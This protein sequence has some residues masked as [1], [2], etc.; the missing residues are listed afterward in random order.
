VIAARARL[1][2]V[3]RANRFWQ[4]IGMLGRRASSRATLA[5]VRSVVCY[6]L[7][8]G[9]CHSG[10]AQTVSVT[11]TPTVDTCIYSGRDNIQ[12]NATIIAG[13][14][15]EGVK[16]R[17]LLR[18]DLTSIPEVATILSARVHLTVVRVPQAAADSDFSLFRMV[19]PWGEEATW[20]NAT[21]NISWE[22]PGALEGTDY[23]PESSATRRISKLGVYEFESTE[24]LIADVQN[25]LDDPASNRGWL[26]KTA[27]EK[28]IETARH[29]GSSESGQP[30]Q[31]L[32]E[33]SMQAG[34]F[35]SEVH[36]QGPNLVL[37]LKPTAPGTYLLETRTN[38]EQ[39][40]WLSV[41]NVSTAE[42]KIVTFT[43]PLV[44]MR[45]FYRAVLQ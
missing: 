2:S 43:V 40:A 11:L 27:S 31:L 45:A 3:E 16:D 26:L 23:F 7:M 17:G 1:L 33:Y 20:S 44:E 4:I 10:T 8:L 25:W 14:R 15:L 38:V 22:A 39:A 30:P 34:P 21:A 24:K 29:F 35:F 5:V 36:R 32:I 37:Q 13:T 9:C 42:L 6:G 41:T 12:G 28:V 18:F 19:T